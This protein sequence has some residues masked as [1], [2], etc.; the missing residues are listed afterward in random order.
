M[1]VVGGYVKGRGL[2]PGKMFEEVDGG[3]KGYLTVG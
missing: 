1:G 3:R 2:R